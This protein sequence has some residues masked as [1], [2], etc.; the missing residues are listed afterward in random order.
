MQAALT[1]ADTPQKM[2]FHGRPQLPVLAV[3]SMVMSKQMPI[4]AAA[5]IDNAGAIGFWGAAMDTDAFA[6]YT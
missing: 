2:R 1:P 4:E 6:A 5:D 3:M